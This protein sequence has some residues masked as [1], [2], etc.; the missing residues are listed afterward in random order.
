MRS[1]GSLFQRTMDLGK[2][3]VYSNRLM[4]ESVCKKE[5]ACGEC[6]QCILMVLSIKLYIP[7]S[8]WSSVY[9][10][11]DESQVIISQKN[12]FLFSLKIDFAL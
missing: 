1:A 12:V 5:S 2:M 3:S 4:Y 10:C 11:V 6:T 7:K 9:T 8:E